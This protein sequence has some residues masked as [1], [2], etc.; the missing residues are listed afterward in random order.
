MGYE[1]KSPTEAAKAIKTLCGNGISNDIRVRVRALPLLITVSFIENDKT[2]AEFTLVEQVNCCGAMVST[3]TWVMQSHA[4]R[5]IA[6]A[7]MP[8]KEAIAKE[9]GYSTL[10]A[11][12]NMSGNPKE[13]HI[14]NKQGWSKGHEFLN[15][16]TGN[17][18]GFFFKNI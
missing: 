14:L 2:F 11:T 13:V 10:A 4:G 12:V 15:K 16:R 5:G 7:M 3:R 8:L 18:V 1:L 17:T 9:F 6:Q